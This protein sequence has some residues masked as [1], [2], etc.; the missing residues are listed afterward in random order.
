[1]PKAQSTA[2]PP[3]DLVSLA[4]VPN[5]PMPQFPPLPGG[6]LQGL[7]KV[8]QVKPLELPGAW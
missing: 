3:C 6:W 5:F 4:K 7:N 8:L 2:A 1:M